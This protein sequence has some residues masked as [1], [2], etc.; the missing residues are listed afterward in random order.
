MDWMYLSRFI[1]VPK[2]IFKVLVLTFPATLHDIL[3]ENIVL[4]LNYIYL[5]TSV[6]DMADCML[7]Q[8]CKLGSNSQPGQ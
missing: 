1:Q 3:E 8:S 5:M 2:S 4:L 7:H 6:S